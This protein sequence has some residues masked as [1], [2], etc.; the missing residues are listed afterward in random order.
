MRLLVIE[1]S[2]LLRDS[3]VQ[4]LRVA[5]YRV[6]SCA[7]GASGLKRACAEEYDL[8]VLDLMLPKVDGLEILRTIRK[9]ASNAYVLILTARDATSDR[10]A[11]LDSGAD[12]YLVK[13][14]EFPEL[15]ARVRV[16]LRRKESER[17]P[18]RRIGEL[19][20]N[21]AARTASRNGDSIPLSAREYALLELLANRAG[22][23]VSRTEIWRQV[24]GLHSAAD[25]NVVDVF[26]GL[27]R[28]KLE[29]PGLPRL[30]HTKRG[31][32]YM[33]GEEQE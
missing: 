6:D 11:G 5:G 24:Y 33:L 21:S 7:D 10:A 29:K 28:K 15:L 4:G 19:E 31:E 22:E 8:V 20:I 12:D 9:R 23:V 30:I 25:S 2:D 32:G 26:V 17:N 14:F 3:L 1:D 13:P 16:L 18:V 27:L